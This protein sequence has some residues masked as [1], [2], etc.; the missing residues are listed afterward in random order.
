[1]VGSHPHVLKYFPSLPCKK[2]SKTK[3]FNFLL[4][5]KKKK[6]SEL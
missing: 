3:N 6:E 2:I 4:K 5:K 1:M